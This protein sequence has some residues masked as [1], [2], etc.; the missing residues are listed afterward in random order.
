MHT[1]D[2]GKAANQVLEKIPKHTSFS[3]TLGNNAEILQSGAMVNAFYT[4]Q[5]VGK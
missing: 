5:L 3:V 1:L 4:F 2:V